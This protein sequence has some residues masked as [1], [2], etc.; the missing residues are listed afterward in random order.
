MKRSVFPEISAVGS[1]LSHLI[2]DNHSSND[3]GQW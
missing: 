3:A 1:F 2:D